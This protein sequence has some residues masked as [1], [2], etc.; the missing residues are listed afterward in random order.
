MAESAKTRQWSNGRCELLNS[1][2]KVERDISRQVT[3]LASSS[4]SALLLRNHPKRYIDDRVD[5][6]AARSYQVFLR[7]VFLSRCPP[8]TLHRYSP[9]AQIWSTMLL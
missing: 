4:S 8:H 7:S 3:L 6:V 9:K 1:C 5:C 2:I